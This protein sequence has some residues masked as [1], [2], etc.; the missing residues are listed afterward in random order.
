M[1]NP[2]VSINMVVFN[3]GPF[4]GKAINSILNQTFNKFEFII[5]DNE[6]TI[7]NEMMPPTLKVRRF[8]VKEKYSKQLESLY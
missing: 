1:E 7:E 4:I 5:I 3:G 6:F 8:V 2:L